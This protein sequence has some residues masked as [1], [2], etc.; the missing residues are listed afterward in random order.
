MLALTTS[1]V[2]II[3][4]IPK[5]SLNITAPARMLVIGSNV[6]RIDALLPPIKNVPFWK[7]TTAPTFKEKANKTTKSHP[8]TD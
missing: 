7:R 3:V 6:L 1:T 4:K 2:P 5:V 8:E